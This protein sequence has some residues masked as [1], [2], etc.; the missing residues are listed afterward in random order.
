MKKSIQN[1]L[2]SYS[3]LAGTLAATGTVNA[4]I[5]YTDVA[6]DVIVSTSGMGVQIDLDN[7]GIIDFTIGM[8][9]G[10]T[11]SSYAYNEVISN[12][13]Q[14]A[15]NAVS[16]NGTI[17]AAPAYPLNA[18]HVL[19]DTIGPG[20]TWATDTAQ[21]AARVYP[22]S[23]SYNFGNWVGATNNYFGFRFKLGAN[24]H[25]GWARATVSINSDSLILKDYA[26]QSMPDTY[27]LAGAMPVLSVGE[28]SLE[29][30][31]L[32]YSAHK[33]IHVNMNNEEATG[34][35]TVSNVLG[36]VVSTA[37]VSDQVT[38]I[39]METAVTGIYFV[40]VSQSDRK[41]SKKVIIK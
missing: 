39:N 20:N 19:N 5:I 35:I 16:Q 2:K 27:I 22:A 21:F 40:T 38:I 32:V 41:F 18:A 30:N 37:S 11:T 33:N 31:V 10:V 1:K 26:Y 29:A 13:P 36:Q 4:Q 17:G 34:I 3:A 8:A 23:T 7:G 6:P 28:N 25:Y 24:T 12:V 14:N 15:I 9:S